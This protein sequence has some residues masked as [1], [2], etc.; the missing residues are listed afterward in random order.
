[1]A[2]PP[3]PALHAASD[4]RFSFTQ[5]VE[6]PDRRSHRGPNSC[7][8]GRCGAPSRPHCTRVNPTDLTRPGCSQHAQA[9]ES[10]SQGHLTS[11]LP[12]PHKPAHYH[13]TNNVT[14]RGLSP[15]LIPALVVHF[16]AADL[17][18]P[19]LLS[20]PPTNGNTARGYGV[21][22]QGA[23]VGV[24]THARL[25]IGFFSALEARSSLRR[26]TPFC[27]SQRRPGDVFARC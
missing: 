23:G 13:P 17:V 9:S 5:H 6:T 27:W 11:S 24:T 3:L 4:A 22:R 10:P 14:R 25:S 20:T 19:P 18:P 21:S 2:R 15:D 8:T 16:S 12:H 26:G 1:M 7:S